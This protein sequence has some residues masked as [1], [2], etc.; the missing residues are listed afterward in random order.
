METKFTE[1]PWSVGNGGKHEPHTTIY[2]DDTMGSAIASTFMKYTTTSND[3]AKANAHLIA[4]APDMYN[5]LEACLR[6][7]DALYP[8]D[9]STIEDCD[10]SEFKA[11]H[12]LINNI[13]LLLAKARGE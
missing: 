7:F 8:V 10:Y 4:S 13:E 11:V 2:C 12:A 1:S 5:K 9:E 6:A 3:E